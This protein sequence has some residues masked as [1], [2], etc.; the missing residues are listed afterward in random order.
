M[1]LWQKCNP[2]ATLQTIYN[3]PNL[4]EGRRYEFRIFAVNEAGHSPPSSNSSAVVFEPSGAA[5]PPEVIKALHSVSG[6]EGRSARLECEIAGN[7]KAEY[8]WFKGARELVDTMKFTILSQGDKQTLIINDLFGEDADEYT[9]RASNAA[10]TR[11]TRCEVNIKSRPKIFVPPR[12]QDRA[13]F[14]KNETMQIKIPF[15]GWPQPTAT[16]SKDGQ[17]LEPG[18]RFHMELMD[19]HAVLMVKGASKDDNGP[20]RL[21][22]ENEIGSDSCIINVLVVD[23]P[24]PP[25][26]LAIETILDTAI[27]LCWKPPVNDGGAYIT[28]YHI[29]KRE[30]P[31]AEWLP[32][33]RTRYTMFTVEGLKERCSYEFRV[34]AENPH[35]MSDPCEPTAPFQMKDTGKRR[36]G[37]ESKPRG[38]KMIVKALGLSL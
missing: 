31:G 1:E 24:D 33:A 16:W 25:R 3:V 36:R 28:N 6:E 37:Y 23:R 9:C 11:S 5:K 4:I 22:L 29:E 17:K 21:L 32:Y 27:T 35:G 30:Q 38:G 34:R 19:R 14:S 12:F 2:T 10:G 8:R 26:F 20:Y 7:P 18:G 13:Q 15:K